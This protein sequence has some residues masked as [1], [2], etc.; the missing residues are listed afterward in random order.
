MTAVDPKPSEALLVIGRRKRLKPPFKLGPLGASTFSDWMLTREGK[1]RARPE[2][3]TVVGSRCRER[4]GPDPG[5][6][7][8][9]AATNK[10]KA[11]AAILARHFIGSPVISMSKPIASLSDTRD[12]RSL[13]VAGSMR[14]SHSRN[15][16]PNPKVRHHAPQQRQISL[17]AY[18]PT[19]ESVAV[20][21]TRSR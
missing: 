14:N 18:V 19:T 2:S 12:C 15:A 11:S 8:G 16:M 10:L 17:R 20:I 6:V 5:R 3:A 13:A 4:T 1:D 21:V 7:S 9:I